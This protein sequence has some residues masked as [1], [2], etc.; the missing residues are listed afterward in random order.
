MQIFLKFKKGKQREFVEKAI[1]L[2]GSERKLEKI[3]G[4]PKSSLYEYKNEN[5][6]ISIERAKKLADFLKLNIDVSFILNNIERTLPSNWKQKKGGIERINKSKI[7]NNFERLKKDLIIS[8]KKWHKEMKLSHPDI[9]YKSQYERLKKM[10]LY[11]FKTLRGETVRNKLEM[12]VANM[13]FKSNIDYVYEPYLR[14]DQNVYFPDFKIGNIIIECTAWNNEEKAKELKRKI[15]NY[16]KYNLKTFCIIDEKVI[17][18]YKDIKE[19]I[20]MIEDIPLLNARI[21]QI[22]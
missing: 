3:A 2:A 19:S 14:I 8:L 20:I 4:I 13:L 11:K 1:S 6:N 22:S 17:K 16:K 5:C 10:G 15:E 21:A 18:F 7:N 12:E 9:Y